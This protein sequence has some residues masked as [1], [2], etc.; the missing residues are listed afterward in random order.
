MSTSL[1]RLVGA[2]LLTLV[3][4]VAIPAYAADSL[5]QCG[6]DVAVS[7]GTDCPS[8]DCICYTGECTVCDSQ[9]MMMSILNFL[10]TFAVIVAALLFVNAGVL[11]VMSPSNPGNVSRAH[12]IFTNTLIGLIIILVAYLLID[13]VMKSLYA[14]PKAT[15]WGP[16]NEFLCKGDDGTRTYCVDKLTAADLGE[17]PT[18]SPPPPST[19]SSGPADCSN[20]QSLK[21]RFGTAGPVNAPGLQD[22]MNCYL[23]DPKVSALKDSQPL[24]TFDNSH[25]LCN[26]TNGTPLCSPCS[27][28]VNSCHYGRGTG[29]GAMAFDINAKGGNESALAKA[30]QARRAV[31]GGRIGFEGNHTHVSMSACP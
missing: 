30:L 5:V 26:Y 9:I 17:A 27:H 19:G 28:S 18:A 15:E 1:Y 14:N 3:A 31:C 10:I 25:P 6:N 11:Y 2:L 23:A 4:G 24:Y 12:K 16:W 21:E 13:T 22:L 7:Y 8:G 29:K 20:P